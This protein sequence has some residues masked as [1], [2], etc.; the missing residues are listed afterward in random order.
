MKPLPQQPT[1]QCPACLSAFR[2]NGRNRLI[3]HGFRAHNV[4]HGASSGFHTG[5]CMG[6]AEQP[7]GTEAGNA[8]ALRLAADQV[9]LAAEEEALPAFTLAD[10][11]KAIID[12]AVADEI[13]RARRY[14]RYEELKRLTDMRASVTA[15][16]FAIGGRFPTMRGWLSPD[17]L[18][19]KQRRMTQARADQAASRRQHAALLREAVAAFPV[20]A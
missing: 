13:A 7:I 15:A 4:R 3:R 20:A 1:G 12:G 11:E 2:V 14:G 10:A 6:V 18:A 16:D 9:R 8:F 17:A 5:A 19:A